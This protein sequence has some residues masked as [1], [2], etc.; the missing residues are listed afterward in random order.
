MKIAVLGHL[1]HPVV[2]PY[3]GGLEAHTSRVARLLAAR[4]H[5][6]TL[7]AK[8][9]SQVDG[10][11]TIPVIGAD[12]VWVIRPDA[13]TRAEQEARADAAMARACGH[14]AANGFDVVLNNSLNPIPYTALDD[15]PMLTVLH[16][17][18]TLERVEE[19]VTG[20]NWRP[21][22][23]H[24]WVSVSATNAVGWRRLLGEVGVVHNG[25]SLEDWDCGPDVAARRTGR[26]RRLT[27]GRPYAAWSGRITPEKGLHVA[28]DA[29]TRAGLPLLVA[30]PISDRAY[31]Q[32]EIVPRL[33]SSDHHH[34]GHLRERE[35]AC[36]L[37][38]AQVF[39]F[40]SLWAEPFGLAAV[41]AMACGTPVAA[42]PTGAATEIV[43]P[44]GGQV[45]ESISVASLAEAIRQASLADRA[46]VRA[47]AEFFDEQVMVIRYLGIMDALVRAGA[48]LRA[49][50]VVPADDGDLHPVG[51]VEVGGQGEAFPVGG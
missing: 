51:G 9:G 47:Q 42:L 5:E 18:A 23:R 43:A 49:G 40:S 20:P 41:E 28:M 39:V 26:A 7:F 21:G 46:D 50:G 15:M 1:H 24:G 14:V 30:G 3:A 11:R 32:Q 27:G 45:C 38:G 13:R 16:T 4:G 12:L 31:W 25:V 10:V 8:Q 22:P 6:V 35:L 33:A 36:L 37:S 29:A 44:Q 2:Q 34:V 17:P 48:P 19:V